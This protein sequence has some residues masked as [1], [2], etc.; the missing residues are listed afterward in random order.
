MISMKLQKEI[1]SIT[2]LIAFFAL[3]FACICEMC[4][5]SS[6]FANIFLGIF[7]SSL[8]GNIMSITTYFYERNKAIRLFL[9]GCLEFISQWTKYYDFDKDYSIKGLRYFLSLLISTYKKDIFP[10]FGELKSIL[11][12]SQLSKKMMEICA[13]TQSIYILLYK[14]YTKIEYYVHKAITIEELEDYEY[15]FL[16]NEM[17]DLINKL[18]DDIKK[19]M[20]DMKY[21]SKEDLIED[22][23]GG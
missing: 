2:G 7:G 19:I 15:E 23:Y 11:N 16:S 5:D 22:N 8:L 10:L 17:Q 9:D 21:C 12:Y 18:T 13:T 1:A 6:F 20:L 3:L 14:D 4:L